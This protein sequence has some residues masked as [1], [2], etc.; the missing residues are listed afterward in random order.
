[1]IS[2]RGLEGGG[3]YALSAQVRDGAAL[4]LDLMPDVG[5]A[6]VTA[7]LSPDQLE[8]LFDLGYHLKRVDTI[9]ERVFGAA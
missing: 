5:M 6:E 4:V 2:A 9:F 3:I 1:M 8:D 7:R